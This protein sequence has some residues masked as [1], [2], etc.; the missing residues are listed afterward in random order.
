MAELILSKKCSKCGSLKDATEFSK[1]GKSKDGLSSSCKCC[2]KVAA[3]AWYE[4]NKDRVKEAVASYRAANLEKA[5]AASSKWY[6]EN[7]DKAKASQ[8]ARYAKNPNKYSAASAAW[9][10]ENPEKVKLAKASYRYSNRENIRIKSAVYRSANKEKRNIA[11]AAYLS[12]NPGLARVYKSN[13]RARKLEAGGSL[14]KGLAAK[15]FTLQKGKCPCCA[16]PLGGNYHLDHKMPLALGGSNT[17]DN[18]QLLRKRC[19][20]QKNAKH[21]IDF[22]QQRGFLL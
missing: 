12:A 13:R 11:N 16:Q 20:L 15:L 14:S 10:K 18:M 2:I 3:A 4:A 21:P 22:M 19:N 8:S 6:A 5:N 17:D 7:K 9:H 1:H